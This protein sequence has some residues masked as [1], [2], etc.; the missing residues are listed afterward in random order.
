MKKTIKILFVTLMLALF[1]GF[2][3]SVFAQGTPPPPPSGG[4]GQNTNQ[5]AGGNAPLGS[6]VALMLGLS[7]AYGARKA[8][9]AREKLDE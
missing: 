8:W 4:H 1:A 5:P 3:T 9:N 6:A 2:S 7:A